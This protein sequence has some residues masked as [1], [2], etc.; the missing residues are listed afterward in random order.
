MVYLRVTMLRL[1]E[2]VQ[3][4]RTTPHEVEVFSSNLPFPP[5]LLCGHVKKKKKSNYVTSTINNLLSLSFTP[6]QL[7]LDQ[8]K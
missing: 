4:V 8:L 7:I 3:S 2:V 1:Q 5:I 6:D